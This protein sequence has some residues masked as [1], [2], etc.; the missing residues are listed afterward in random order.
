MSKKRNIR[1]YLEDV[2]EAS[3]KIRVYTKDMGLEEFARDEKTKDAVLRNLEV[4]GEAVKNIPDGLKQTH[5]EVNWRAIAGMRNKLIHEYFGVSPQ[6]VWETVKGDIPALS[7]QIR[8]IV[9]HL[10]KE[11]TERV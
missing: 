9:E 10:E 5:T 3:E 11:K 2:L 8:R 4:I 1:I 7:L 6:I